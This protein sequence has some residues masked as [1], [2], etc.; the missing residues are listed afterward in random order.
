MSCLA[1]KFAIKAV[2]S[3]RD[4]SLKG[5]PERIEDAKEKDVQHNGDRTAGFPG[6]LIATGLLAGSQG[7]AG[8]GRDSR[9]L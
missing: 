3:M 8:V 6:W 5:L 4:R 2:D 7:R 1:V 9:Y